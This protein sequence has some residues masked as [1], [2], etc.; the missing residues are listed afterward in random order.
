MMLALTILG[1]AIVVLGEAARFAL[2]NARVARDLAQ[3]QL[4]CESKLA[5]IA[6][7]A[8][9]PEPVQS[10]FL[11][12]GT[13]PNQPVWL[14]SIETETID[15]LGLLAVW[16]TVAQDLPPEKRPVECTLVRWIIDP[17]T[18]MM[19][20]ESSASTEAGTSTSTTTSP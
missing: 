12:E 5:E 7:G 2:D 18:E 17:E 6:A 14:Y 11:A 13:D 20:E 16:V 1:G 10:V 8:E 3:A 4:L 9:L 19:L 15:Q